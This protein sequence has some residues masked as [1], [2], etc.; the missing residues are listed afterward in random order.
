MGS[1]GV[2]DSGAVA[3][4]AVASGAVASGAGASGA[5][6]GM[7][8]WRW[9]LALWIA[10]VAGA[11]L[12]ASPGP[13][14]GPVLG[15][16]LG[17]HFAGLLPASIAGPEEQGPL[18]RL[19]GWADAPVELVRSAARGRPPG[20]GAAV[21]FAAASPG[22]PVLL[23]A[24]PAGLSAGVG[25]LVLG[26]ARGGP[27]QGWRVGGA[28]S[29]WQGPSGPSGAPGLEGPS[30]GDDEQGRAM[31]SAVGWTAIGA[32][33]AR[34]GESQVGAVTL[35]HFS[36]GAGRGVTTQVL[37]PPAGMAGGGFGAALA[38]LEARGEPR[39]LAV[40]APFE[41]D[42]V[43]GL[44]LVGAVH[45]FEPDRRWPADARLARQGASRPRPCAPT[46]PRDR[47]GLRR[48]PRLGRSGRSPSAP[49]GTWQPRARRR[50]RASVGPEVRG[51]TL[52]PRRRRE[53]GARSRRRPLLPSPVAWGIRDGPAS[54]SAA[55]GARR[56]ARAR[57]PGRCTRRRS[58][59]LQRPAWRE[60]SA[61]R[62]RRPGRT[63]SSGRPSPA[64]RGVP[65]AGRGPPL[66]RR[67]EGL[68]AVETLAAPVADDRRRVRGL[69][70]PRSRGRRR[71]PA[72]SP[73][74]SRGAITAA[75]RSARAAARVGS[76]SSCCRDRVGGS[77]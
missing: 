53:P 72:G 46:S 57:P 20:L 27:Q 52:D 67:V 21:S 42:P 12:Q 77:R 34:L 61:S 63:S 36:P 18:A 74:A 19:D 32:P 44:P 7:V 26:A 22:G 45:L 39:V 29:W 9:A 59:T 58:P 56:G 54:R 37:R 8:R 68:A 51:A 10:A 3:S 62:W 50:E 31:A 55:A 15:A 47:D 4:W 5:R 1:S 11:G 65:L 71:R 35:V 76:L 13:G 17:R 23:G 30:R 41:T 64:S 38:F 2:E 70:S 40:G 14:W 49:P 73:W 28:G 24:A 25:G 69:R 75:I 66:P 16:L 43:T 48:L 6:A 33:S 60:A